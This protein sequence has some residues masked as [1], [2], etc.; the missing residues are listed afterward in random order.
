MLLPSPC[1]ARVRRQAANVLVRYLGGDPKLVDEVCQLRELQN[2][3]KAR[4]PEA[5][6][7][8][9][10]ETVEA[11]PT[12]VDEESM[13]KISAVMTLMENRLMKTLQQELQQTHPWDFQKNVSRHN[14]SLNI[15]SIVEGDAL[16]ALDEDEHVISITDF[17]KARVNAATWKQ[18]GNKLKNIFAVELKRA[19]TE[20]AEKNETPLFIARMQGEYRIV[21]TEADEDLMTS[22]FH[23]CKRRLAGIVTRDEAFMKAKRKQRRIEDYFTADQSKTTDPPGSYDDE[24]SLRISFASTATPNASLSPFLSTANGDR[25][26]LHPSA[27]P[28]APADIRL[29]AKR[30]DANVIMTG[31]A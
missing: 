3:C 14:S 29:R 4:C 7:R 12:S 16:T 22:I 6:A 10:G 8:F 21:Y 23:K 18:H 27:I 2:V 5:P 26:A 19:K 11:S 25:V 31:G 30:G 13:Q 24:E 17:L 28:D 9:F 15:G 1:A 20:E